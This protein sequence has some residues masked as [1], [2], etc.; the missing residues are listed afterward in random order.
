MCVFVCVYLRSQVEVAVDRQYW[1]CVVL[2]AEGEE[3]LAGVLEVFL[4][5]QLGRCSQEKVLTVWGADIL[6][7]PH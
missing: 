6:G 4:Q 3:A 7:G 5:E 2:G 1:V